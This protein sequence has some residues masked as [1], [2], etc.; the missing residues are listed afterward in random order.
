MGASTYYGSHWTYSTSGSSLDFEWG[1]IGGSQ[2]GT[3]YNMTNGNPI[4]I[5]D[6]LKVRLV[7]AF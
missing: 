6:V 2:M 5:E 1:T 4:L 7:R 3:T